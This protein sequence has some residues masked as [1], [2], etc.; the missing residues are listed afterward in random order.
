M[1]FVP[2]VMVLIPVLRIIPVV[3]RW[4]IKLRLYRWYRVLLVLEQDLMAPL[5][6]EKREDLLGRL[7]H[8]EKEVSKMK[9]PASFGDQFY[10]LPGHISCVRNRLM[11]SSQSH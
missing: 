10:G 7:D 11:D 8:I 1:A 4:R 2:L 5:A 6:S 3:Y 9:V